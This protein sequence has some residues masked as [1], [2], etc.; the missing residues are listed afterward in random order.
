MTLP[1]QQTY[2]KTAGGEVITEQVIDKL[3]AEAEA[4]Y[5]VD[6]DLATPE[7][8]ADDRFVN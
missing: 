4:G 6:K 3:S 8:E 1:R 7:G 2:G 5:D